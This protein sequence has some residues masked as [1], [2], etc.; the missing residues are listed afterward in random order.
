MEAPERAAAIDI[1]SNTVH[2]LVA[3]WRDGRIEP[4]DDASEL[5]G[6][7]R[8]VY[9]GAA[10]APESLDRAIAAVQRL[11][12][13]AR[14]R[15]ARVARLVATAAVRDASNRD[16]VVAAVRRR[17]GLDLELI[18]GEREAALSYR[19]A[20]AGETG[21]GVDSVQ[22]CDVGG[23]STEVIRVEDGRFTLQTSLPL[24]SSRLADLYQSDPPTADELSRVEAAAARELAA[25]P[26]WRPARLI[27]TGGTATTLAHVAGARARRYVMTTGHLSALRDLLARDTA[28]AVAAAYTVE[29]ARARLLPAGAAIIAALCAAASVEDVVLTAAGLRDGLLIEYFTRKRE[30]EAHAHG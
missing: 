24:G 11:A 5:V 25:L 6:L 4:L 9:A 14:S 21:A 15:G 1:G 10:I 29:P 2:M 26:A 19:G 17:S 13:R 23:G 12:E 8:G 30:K 27:V 7:A 28:G 18:S 3:A 16:E 20:A 22:V